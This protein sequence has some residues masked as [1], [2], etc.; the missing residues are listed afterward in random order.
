MD[1][2]VRSETYGQGDHTWLGSAHG[3][4]TGETITLDLSTFDFVSDFPDGYLP[5]GVCLG[6]ITASG[7]YGA[8]GASP[9]EVQTITVDA[10]GGNW[11]IT[12]NGET[13]GN[14]PTNSSAATVQAALE[15]T[16][17]IDPGDVTVTRSGSAN[18]YV[19]TLTFAGQYLGKNVPAC[20]TG[21]G[22]LT[23]GAGTATVATSTGGGGTVSDGSETLVG[24]LLH[25]VKVDADNTDG[26]ALGT[27]FTHGKVKESKLPTHHGLD[28]AGK[29]DVAGRIRYI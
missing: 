19:Y 8:Y 16:S 29:A 21:A 18:S 24:H 13:T 1:M 25:D 2:I 20:T 11:T 14:I 12:F 5:S 7:L 3:T 6:L 4:E 22:S 28:A 23:G 9:S 10:T 17:A 27:L 15:A 26:V